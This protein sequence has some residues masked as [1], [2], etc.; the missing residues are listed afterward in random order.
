MNRITLG[1]DVKEPKLNFTNKVEGFYGA[2]DDNFLRAGLFGG[3]RN[4]EGETVCKVQTVHN[5]KKLKAM[6]DNAVH[7]EDNCIS[8]FGWRCYLF[9]ENDEIKIKTIKN[10]SYD[11]TVNTSLGSITCQDK[12]E[13]GGSLIL[14]AENGEEYYYDSFSCSFEDILEYGG[15]VYA[16][17]S[18]AHMFGRECALHEIKKSNGKYQIITVFECDDMYFSGYYLDENYL[19]FYSNEHYNGLCRFNLD[20]NQLEI[21][22]T[23]LCSTIDVNSLIKKDNFIYIHGN[24]NI[25]KY[26]LNTREIDSIYTNLEYDEISEFWFVNN[27]VKLIDVWDELIIDGEE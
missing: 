23:D 1:K 12:G 17:S 16:I 22:H 5:L 18:L 13:W 7:K 26:D 24:Y 3:G 15:K 8:P 10:K 9:L 25:V 4:T 27:D 20:N 21:I 19:Y 2:D 11:K 14:I 6:V